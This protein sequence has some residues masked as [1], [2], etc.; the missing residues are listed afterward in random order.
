[1]TPYTKQ[2]VELHK[3]HKAIENC[4]CNKDN[5]Q[6][7]GSNEITI[8]DV[9]KFIHD[10]IE[11]IAPGAFPYTTWDDIPEYEDVNGGDICKTDKPGNISGFS[12]FLLNLPQYIIG[13]KKS[14]T[15]D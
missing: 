7:G 12:N 3:I 6:G 8:D 10:N 9:V 11:N 15:Y 4:E 1:M 13:Q 5:E 2:I 14:G